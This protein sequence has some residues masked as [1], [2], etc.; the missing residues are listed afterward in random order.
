MPVFLKQQFENIEFI[1]WELTEDVELLKEDIN[2]PAISE[3][4]TKYK[5][6]K[7]K[8]EFL[9]SRLALKILFGKNVTVEYDAFGAPYIE[10][11]DWKI[12]IT[13]SGKYVA[14]ARSKQNLG[15]DI[16]Q[17][18]EKL[19]RTKHK[20]SSENELLSIDTEQ[21]LFHLALYWSGK[22]SVYKWVG[23]EALIFDSEMQIEAFS[24]KS[25]GEFSL[26]LKCKTHQKLMTVHYLKLED[27]VFTYCVF[28]NGE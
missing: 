7:R 21:K 27:Y 11:N 22:E 15:I 17:I 1:I 9:C 19:N 13:H 3:Q 5:T 6:E 18:S 26:Q 25:S 12:S 2:Q 14:V 8:K 16:E 24:P 20:F 4:V 23:N 10:N 28:N